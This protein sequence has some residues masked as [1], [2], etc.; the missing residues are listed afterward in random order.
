MDDA[1][2]KLDEARR[3]VTEGER[4]ET[5]FLALGGVT[6]VALGAAGTLALIVLLVWFLVR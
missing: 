6:V 1:K 5:P 3:T 2:D 4:E